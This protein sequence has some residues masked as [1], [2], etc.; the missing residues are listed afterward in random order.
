VHGDGTFADEQGA[1][2]LPV[3]VPVDQPRQYFGFPV[4]EVEPGPG[5]G[6]ACGPD[7]GRGQPG[8]AGQVL[9]LGEQGNG[10]EFPGHVLARGQRAHGL[11]APA[12]PDGGRGLTQPRIRLRVGLPGL[13][14]GL[15][16]V[17]PRRAGVAAEA[18]RIL[19][20]DRGAEGSEVWLLRTVLRD[21]EPGLLSEGDGQLLPS[22]RDI[23]RP[24]RVG[25]RRQVGGEPR[26]GG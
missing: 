6:G 3:A 16:H 14:P 7:R 15:G 8:P 9:R 21:D 4:G 2:D 17:A 19:G 13:V 10:L 11:F 22:V 24:G 25:Q 20:G 5:L 26:A 23:P 1:G 12:G 18:A